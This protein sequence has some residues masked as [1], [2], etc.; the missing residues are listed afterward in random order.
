[1]IEK[2]NKIYEE[3]K[4]CDSVFWSK[5]L[6]LVWILFTLDIALV[7][8]VVLFPRKIN[9]YIQFVLFYSIILFSILLMIIIEMSSSINYEAKV[10]YKLLSSY[11][12]VC[13]QTNSQSSQWPDMG[14]RFN[15]S[16]KYKLINLFF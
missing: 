4:E 13:I 9:F 3:I 7:I 1:M 6:A 16:E 8:F 12:L 14:L 2:L 5:F 11:K 10:T 15:F